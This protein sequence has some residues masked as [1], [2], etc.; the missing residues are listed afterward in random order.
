MNTSGNKSDRFPEPQNQIILDGVPTYESFRREIESL[1]AVQVSRLFHE[2][3][4]RY[5]PFSNDVAG[6]DI[7]AQQLVEGDFCLPDFK[8]YLGIFISNNF[9]IDR[10]YQIYITHHEDD[11]DYWTEGFI[12]SLDESAEVIRTDERVGIDS[13]FYDDWEGEEISINNDDRDVNTALGEQMGINNNPVGL[14]EM[15]TIAK[16]IAVAVASGRKTRNPY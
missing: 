1:E 3:I 9:H 10:N 12:Y 4:K 7:T 11:T 2:I 16:I 8:G 15:Q 6:G 13:D 14:T 5:T